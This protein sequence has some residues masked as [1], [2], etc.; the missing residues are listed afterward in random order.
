MPSRGL[1]SIEDHLTVILVRI[2]DLFD[3]LSHLWRLVQRLLDH[4][5]RVVVKSCLIVGCSSSDHRRASDISHDTRR[6]DHTLATRFKGLARAGPRRV[7]I[8][9]KRIGITVIAQV[10]ERARLVRRMT[11]RVLLEGARRVCCFLFPRYT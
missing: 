2:V 9:L 7:Y 1:A 3:V 4:R 11:Q 8:R 6:L 5:V 10:E